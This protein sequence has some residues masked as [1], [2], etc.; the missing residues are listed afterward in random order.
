MFASWRT[1]SQCFVPGWHKSD[2]RGLRVPQKLLA[3]KYILS[4]DVLA[5]SLSVLKIMLFFI[6]MD[7]V[8]RSCIFLFRIFDS[9]NDAK[10]NVMD[11]LPRRITQS[12]S[13]TA[14]FR[15][16]TP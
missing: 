10:S 16:I 6:V 9:V 1:V 11:A 7:N 2:D 13:G 8:C 15:A 4:F 5:L 3:G 12:K 14:P